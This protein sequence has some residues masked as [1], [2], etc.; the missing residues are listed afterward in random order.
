MQTICLEIKIA[1]L[2]NGQESLAS[3][4]SLGMKFGTVKSIINKQQNIEPLKF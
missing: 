1:L 2:E 3:F 4:A